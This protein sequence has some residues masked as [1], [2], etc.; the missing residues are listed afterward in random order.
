ML[1]R[2]KEEILDTTDKILG[3]GKVLDGD[4]VLKFERAIAQRTHRTYAVAVNSCTQALIF[5][6]IYNYLDY[7]KTT[8]KILIP[9]ISFIATLNSVLMSGQTP[10]FCDTDVD[11]IMDLDSLDNNL[12]ELGI[13]TVMYVNLYGNCIDYDRFTTHTKFFNNN[14]FVIEDAAQSF[15]ASYKGIPSGKL[16]TVS[17][18]S[19]DPTKNLP[20]YGSGGMILT[21]DKLVY[22][23]TLNLR[24]NGKHSLH[25]ITGTNSK[26]SEVDC[27][28]MLVKLN[29][30][31]SWQRRRSEIAEYYTKE[32]DGIVQTPKVRTDT[33]HAW[34][35][36][37]IHF[38]SRN[39]LKDH[40][41]KLGIETKIH[42]NQPLFET[43]LGFNFVNSIKQL[44]RESNKLCMT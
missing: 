15:G 4:Y 32:L 17:C 24:D 27:G 3:T 23:H 38:Y 13:E 28:H 1:F 25:Q 12:Q 5:S 44:Y 21:D 11:G 29:Y 40:L 26:M 18:L 16:G 36:Y 34:H 39:N 42:Y 33:Q 7:K 6:L 8:N 9:S 19:F 30:F 37:V 20:N 10:V 22:E 43:N 35:K 31:D 2:S 41:E 14:I